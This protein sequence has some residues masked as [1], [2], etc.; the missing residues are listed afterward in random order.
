MGMCA[1]AGQTWCTTPLQSASRRTTNWQP[2]PQVLPSANSTH[3][4]GF[5]TIGTQLA[6]WGSWA[7]WLTGNMQG[8]VTAARA[9]M[10]AFL[11]PSVRVLRDCQRWHR[12]TDHAE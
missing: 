2:R 10:Q 11:A 9:P 12:C 4:L 5:N 3:S 8:V 7:V 1:Q 6:T